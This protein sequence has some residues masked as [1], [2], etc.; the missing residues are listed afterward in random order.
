MSF[1]IKLERSNYQ[2]DNQSLDISLHNIVYV[3][4]IT[5]RTRKRSVRETFIK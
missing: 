3:V 1:K 5:D 4:Q 2:T